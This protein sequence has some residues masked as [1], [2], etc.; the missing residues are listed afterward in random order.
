MSVFKLQVLILAV[1]SEICGLENISTRKSNNIVLKISDRRTDT[2]GTSWA[3]SFSSENYQKSV[4]CVEYRH[5]NFPAVMVLPRQNKMSKT[6][7]FEDC[8]NH[9]IIST[10][11]SFIFSN[12]LFCRGNINYFLRFCII[13]WNTWST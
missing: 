10:S 8:W 12:I 4:F 11:D 13:L 9:H 6:N 3:I 7:R 2:Q 1:I 5:C